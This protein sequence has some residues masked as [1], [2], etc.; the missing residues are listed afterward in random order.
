MSAF[1]MGICCIGV[2][3]ILS[4][5]IAHLKPLHSLDEPD[6]FELVSKSGGVEICTLQVQG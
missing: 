2:G 1:W 3:R 6:G 5:R 4:T